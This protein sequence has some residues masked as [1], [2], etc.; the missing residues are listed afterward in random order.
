MN[1]RSGLSALAVFSLLGTASAQPQALQAG[2]PIPVMS[3]TA[4]SGRWLERAALEPETYGKVRGVSPG[5]SS[6]P[7]IVLYTP[8]LNAEF[9]KIAATVDNYIAN[10]PELAWSYVMVT[11]AKGAQRGGYTATELRARLDEIKVLA[12][13]HGIR[14]LSFLVS[15]PGNKTTKPKKTAVIAYSHKAATPEKH[16][17]VSWLTEIPLDTPSKFMPSQ[18]VSS[19]DTAISPKETP[20]N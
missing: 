5:T 8:V 13:R 1:L 17:I 3:A 11:D 19:L 4:A 14:H 9:F 10:R 15:A 7:K 12:A 18:L 20:P 16:P 6:E 2:K